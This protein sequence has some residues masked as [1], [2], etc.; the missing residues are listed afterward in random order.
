MRALYAAEPDGLVWFEDDV[1]HPATASAVE[2]LVQADERGLSPEDYDAPLL[3]AR[4]QELRLGEELP[5]GRTLFDLGLSLGL[6]RHL[7][8]VHQG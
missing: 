1:V 8:D 7:R 5:E 3:A 2:A 4:L 6:L